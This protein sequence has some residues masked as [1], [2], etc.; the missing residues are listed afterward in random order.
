[1]DRVASGT[2]PT[3]LIL[4]VFGVLALANLLAFGLFGWDKRQARIGGWRV[5]ESDLLKMAF[6]GGALGAKLGQRVFRHK[7]YKQP[8]GRLLNAI[9]VVQYLA[10]GFLLVPASWINGAI[11]SIGVPSLSVITQVSDPPAEKKR[12]MPRR[13]GP[14]SEGF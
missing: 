13:F 4:V 9:F 14:G 1:M 3:V 10:F 8:F 11:A 6:L 7:T 5:S 2:E 12:A